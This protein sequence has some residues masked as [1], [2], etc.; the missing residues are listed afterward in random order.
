VHMGA[1]KNICSKSGGAEENGKRGS[2]QDETQ[3]AVWHKKRGSSE[4][5]SPPH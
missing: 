3:F 5:D 4:F 1:V 2:K